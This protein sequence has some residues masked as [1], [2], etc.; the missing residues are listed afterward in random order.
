METE[1]VR[2]LT[3]GR[4]STRCYYCPDY[5]QIT[6]NQTP[7][8]MLPGY[9]TGQGNGQRYGGEGWTAEMQVHMGDTQTGRDRRDRLAWWKR[10][11]RDEKEENK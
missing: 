9:I 4:G 2:N 1:N 5:I 11:E 10:V 8:F 3:L 6:Q 7:V